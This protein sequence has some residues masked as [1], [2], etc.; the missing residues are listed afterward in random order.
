MH[1][2]WSGKD[3]LLTGIRRGRFL[4]LP[5]R[6]HFQQPRA[7]GLTQPTLSRQVASLEETLGV[8]LFER[9]SRALLLAQAG[10]QLLEHFRSM[11]EAANRISIAA[12]GQFEAVTGHVAIACTNGMATFFLPKILKNFKP[13]RQT[14]RSKSS[15]PTR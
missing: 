12:T 9:T 6:D 11:G 1:K 13:Q 3:Q 7:L 5:K 4:P 15:R 14:F 8:T 10:T 2:S